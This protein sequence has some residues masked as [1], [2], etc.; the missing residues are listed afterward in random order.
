MRVIDDL[1]SSRVDVDAERSVLTI[2][3]TPSPGLRVG[4]L[5]CVVLG[6]LLCAA[7]IARF[8]GGGAVVGIVIGLAFLAFGVWF[9]GAAFTFRIDRDRGT[10]DEERFWIGRTTS[11]SHRKL[12]G[13]V[14]VRIHK[15]TGRSVSF[16]VLL[17]SDEL[18]SYLASSNDQA[19]AKRLAEMVR[20]HLRG[21][22]AHTC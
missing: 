11:R 5:V 7:C 18:R 8:D 14:E 4:C 6:V 1:G 9:G 15:N 16:D 17:V 10:I 22:P 12:G 13:H 19:S 20:A 3:S 21:E 2:A